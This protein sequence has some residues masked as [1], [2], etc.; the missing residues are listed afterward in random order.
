MP[1]LTRDESSLR[2][3]YVAGQTELEFAPRAE[4]HVPVALASMAAKYVRELAMRLFNDFWKEHVPGLRATQGYPA[5]ARRF[6]EETAAA[7]ARLGM[8][9]SD[10]WRVR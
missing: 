8:A 9:D 3:L 2:S 6:Q 5:D 4:R 1:V 7:R 10:F